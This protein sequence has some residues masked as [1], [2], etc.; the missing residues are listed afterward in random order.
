MD[1]GI[2]NAL[3]LEAERLLAEEARLEYLV[4]KTERDFSG[5]RDIDAILRLAAAKL[6]LCLNLMKRTAIEQREQIIAEKALAALRLV[7]SLLA[8]NVSEDQKGLIQEDPRYAEVRSLLERFLLAGGS[9]FLEAPQA[10]ARRRRI[11]SRSIVAAIRR[12]AAPDDRSPPLILEDYPPFIQTVLRSLFPVMVRENP[13]MPPYGIEE[14]E[15]VVHSSPNMKLPL[16]QAIF[17]MENELIPELEKKIAEDP[18]NSALQAE[19]RQVRER[20]EDYRKLRFFPRSTP[21]LLE[22]GYYTDGMTSYTTE[23]EMLVPIPLAVTMRSGTN[24]DRTMEQVRTDVVRRIAG[25]K[26]SDPLDREYQRLRS[27]ESGR[28]G[29]SR[30]PS[31]RLDPAWGYRVLRQEFP[32]LARLADKGKFQELV[33]IV[34]SGST[35][36]SERRIESLIEKDQQGIPYRSPALIEE[37]PHRPF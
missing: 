3:S 22:K 36:A 7:E 5:L 29:N 35:A 2:Q 12:H 32:F 37:D 14:G 19:V 25:R 23:G 28:Q 26:V 10:D 11:L 20:V 6:S 34:T 13:E 33:N 18:G 30:T 17:Y 9:G 21:V 24:L 8:E 27:L 4:Q 1:A 15:E 16:S 31:M